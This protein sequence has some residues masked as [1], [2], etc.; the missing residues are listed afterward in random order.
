MTQCPDGRLV[1]RDVL[2]CDG[3][4][5]LDYLTEFLHMALCVCV[6]GR[7]RGRGA[8]RLCRVIT[9]VHNLLNRGEGLKS[10]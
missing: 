2:L 10:L 8:Q 4:V 1:A 9:Y 3:S 5:L 6:R 7:G